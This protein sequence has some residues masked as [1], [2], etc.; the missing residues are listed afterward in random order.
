MARNLDTKRS[1]SAPP[2]TLA[3]KADP[4]DGGKKICYEFKKSGTCKKGADC[5][6]EH[7]AAAPAVGKPKRKASPRQV[8][9]TPA[10]SIFELEPDAYYLAVNEDTSKQVTFAKQKLVMGLRMQYKKDVT[11]QRTN[12]QPH[13][14]RIGRIHAR[15][16]CFE[17]ESLRGIYHLRREIHGETSSER[18]GKGSIAKCTL[19]TQKKKTARPVV[20]ICLK[21][22]MSG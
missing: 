10:I 15:S 16:L 2:K 14:P 18:I 7:V 6:Y 17:H 8:H 13:D 3:D 22:S 5:A 9:G 11:H 20:R 1:A 4:K 19:M 12:A 21:L